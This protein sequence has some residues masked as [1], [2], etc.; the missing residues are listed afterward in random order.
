MTDSIATQLKQDFEG[1]L[2]LSETDAPFEVI[3]WPAQG[4]LTP[5][6]LLQP[7]N[8]PRDFLH[9]ITPFFP[10]AIFILL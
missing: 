1:L 6:K 4:K 7:T 3:N 10:T 2:C 5:A 8:H 9:C